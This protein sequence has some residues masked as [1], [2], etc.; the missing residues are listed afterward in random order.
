MLE[1]ETQFRQFARIAQNYAVLVSEI[2]RKADSF[3]PSDV[4]RDC[5]D[6]RK[7][8]SYVTSGAAA[9]VPQ[10]KTIATNA[11]VPARIIATVLSRLLFLAEFL[12]SRIAAQRIPNRI[13]PK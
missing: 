1:G 9:A 12:E 13:E 10:I 7:V 6:I 4:C 11:K 3:Q 8:D 5:R 2:V